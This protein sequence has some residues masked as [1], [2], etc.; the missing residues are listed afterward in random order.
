[1]I[2][3]LM[4][5][6]IFGLPLPLVI[7]AALAGAYLIY[8]RNQAANAAAAPTG[9]P[10]TDSGGADASSDSGDG[11]PAYAGPG[12]TNVYSQP[13]GTPPAA[14]RVTK[15]KR[16]PVKKAPKRRPVVH[17]SRALKG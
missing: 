13:V 12:V 11:N 10:G 1:M 16:S 3:G 14:K 5:K 15:R 9:D 4:G 7:V 17:R 2:K 8:R 6:K